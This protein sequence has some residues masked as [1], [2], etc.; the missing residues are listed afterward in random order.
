MIRRTLNSKRSDILL[1]R[2]SDLK[3]WA[4]LL[5]LLALLAYGLFIAAQSAAETIEPSLTTPT[6]PVAVNAP[7]APRKAPVTGVKGYL[8]TVTAFSDIECGSAWFER[9]E[10]KDDQVALNFAKYGR[11]DNVYVPAFDKTYRVVGST[12]GKTDLD[13]WFGPDQ[14]AALDFGVEELLINPL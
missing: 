4:Y 14:E 13:I 11:H 8:A 7:Q 3:R 12:D 9:H 2:K 5:G 10:P 6:I 1:V